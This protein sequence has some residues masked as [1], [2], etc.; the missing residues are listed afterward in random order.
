MKKKSI[1]LYLDMLPMLEE[2]KPAGCGRVVLALLRYASEGT[3]ANLRGCEH[4]AY[5]FIRSQL[6]RDAEKYKLRCE[7]NRTN[8]HRG[9]RPPL[10]EEG[11]CKKPKKPKQTEKTQW[12]F[13]KPKK[14]DT[15]T[16]TDTDTETETETETDTD[17]ETDTETETETELSRAGSAEESG[18][19]ALLESYRREFLKECPSLPKPEPAAS[20]TPLRKERLWNLQVSREEFGRICRQVE[21][22]DFLTGRSGKWTGCSLDWLLRPEN[23]QKVREGNYSQRKVPSGDVPSEGPSFDLEEYERASRWW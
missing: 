7:R 16:D 8:G 6:D 20:W 22:S 17:T 9:G 12:V 19:T 1:L 23:W 10:V 4:M 5:S 2:L 15:D 13:E 18:E 14:A 21:E 3:E 11:T